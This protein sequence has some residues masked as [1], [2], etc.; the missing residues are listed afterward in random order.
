MMECFVF[1]S[2]FS[3]ASYG[4]RDQGVIF[5]GGHLGRVVSQVKCIGSISVVKRDS[6]WPEQQNDSV[7]VCLCRP[8]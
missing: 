2:P 3:G 4:S 1:R 5:H 7:I 6:V 8:V